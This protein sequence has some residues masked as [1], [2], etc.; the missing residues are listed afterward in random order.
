MSLGCI[1]SSEH[2]V[3][4]SEVLGSRGVA[5]PQVQTCPLLGQLKM[6]ECQLMEGFCV[7]SGLILILYARSLVPI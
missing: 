7:I 4:F 6:Q 2:R 1:E 5:K 3:Q